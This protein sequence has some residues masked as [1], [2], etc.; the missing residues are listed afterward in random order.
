MRAANPY[1]EYYSVLSVLRAVVYTLPSEN[2]NDGDLMSITH[3]KAINIVFDWLA[4][5]DKEHAARLKNVALQL[6]AQREVISYKAPASGDS[7]LGEDYDLVELLIVLAEVAQLNSELLEASVTKNAAAAD[8]E[9][10]D[11][12]INQIANFSLEGFSFSDPED[13]HRLGYAQRKQPRPYNLALFMTEG[14]TEDF[15]GAWDGNED[16]DEMFTNGPPSNW[17]EIFDIP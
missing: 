5:F 4:K 11:K 6:K 1:F 15:I 8:F 14:Q 7:I 16:M 9:V 10:M 12:H 17:Q 13:R 2:W 3:S